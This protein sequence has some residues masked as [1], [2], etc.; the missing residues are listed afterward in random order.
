MFQIFQKK[1]KEPNNKTKINVA[2]LNQTISS[3]NI[4]KDII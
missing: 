2:T 3:L 1:T 4:T